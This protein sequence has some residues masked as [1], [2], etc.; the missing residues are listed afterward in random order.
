[1][2]RN[3]LLINLIFLSLGWAQAIYHFDISC[4]C[5]HRDES[6]Y[7]LV[8]LELS[9]MTVFILVY[10]LFR[11]PSAYKKLEEWNEDYL[12]ETYTIVFNT[13]VPEGDSTGEKVFN[14][15]RA[16]FPELASDYVR[17]AAGTQDKIKLYFKK[18]LGRLQ[19]LNISQ[20][21]NYKINPTYSVDLALKLPLE[22]YFIVKDFKEKVVTIDELNYLAKTISGKFKDKYHPLRVDVFRAICVAKHYDASFLNRESLERLMKEDLK[23]KFDIDL[24]VEEK[25]GY[26]VLWVD[27]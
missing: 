19:P 23:A 25:V 5:I 1:L 15:A 17:L 14:L 13:T 8:Y 24:L 16:V 21:L 9:L 26:S 18:K 4:F 2:L 20:S 10:F 3:L 22:G 11:G 27:Y 7:G 12:E 6:F